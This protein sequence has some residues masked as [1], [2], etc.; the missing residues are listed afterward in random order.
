MYWMRDC[1]IPVT[2]KQTLGKC[3]FSFPPSRSPSP[4]SISLCPGQRDYGIRME[5]H[6]IV[7][8]KPWLPVS[9]AAVSGCPRQQWLPRQVHSPVSSGLEALS[10]S[11]CTQALLDEEA[12]IRQVSLMCGQSAV[13]QPT[14]P[15]VF[16][17]LTLHP[18]GFICKYL[19]PSFPGKLVKTASKRS[20]S[21]S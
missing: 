18:Q 19:G 5:A 6:L 2:R 21:F 17:H 20:S 1:G 14:Q 15:E 10:Q 16:A 8:Q 13:F 7:S 4:P 11:E 12:L 9:A 3:P